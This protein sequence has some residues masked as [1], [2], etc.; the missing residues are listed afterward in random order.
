MNSD[1]PPPTP[2]D[3]RAMDLHM[4]ISRQARALW[5]GYGCPVGRDL[6]IWL[7]A[8]RQV[9]GTDAQTRQSASGAVSAAV[10]AAA[11]Y[12]VDERSTGVQG[13]PAAMMPAGLT[14]RRRARRTAR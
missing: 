11:Q 6:G 14:P 1:T 7:E 2:P 10:D 4:E 12:P 3:T 8:E 9:L 5:E 13:E